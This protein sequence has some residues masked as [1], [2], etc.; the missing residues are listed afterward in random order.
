MYCLIFKKNC[1]K[2]GTYNFIRSD[3]VK[4]L[5]LDQAFRDALLKLVVS[6]FSKYG[7][8]IINNSNNA[9]LIIQSVRTFDL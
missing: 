4:K 8:F 5:A 6:D 7:V 9:N 3:D 1:R 2:K